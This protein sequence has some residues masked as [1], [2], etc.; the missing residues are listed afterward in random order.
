MWFWNPLPNPWQWVALFV[1]IIALVGWLVTGL[2]CRPKVRLLFIG[3]KYGQKIS[4]WI[5]NMPL[6]KLYFFPRS[7]VQSL[8]VRVAIIDIEAEEKAQEQGEGSWFVCFDEKPRKIQFNDGEIGENIALPASEWGVPLHIAR[9]YIAKTNDLKA[10]AT[11][12]NGV[13]NI[14]LHQGEY[15]AKFILWV[16]GKEYHKDR[17]FK[18]SPKKPNVAWDKDG[19]VKL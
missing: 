13:Y 18:I 12:R 17:M 10:Q 6:S 3:D 19:T 1:G 16:D 7:V 14:E 5:Q 4:C 11:D 8:S 9:A 2:T 15:K